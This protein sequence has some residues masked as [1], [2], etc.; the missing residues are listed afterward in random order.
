[1]NRY[2]KQKKAVEE[3]I[4]GRIDQ[5]KAIYAKAD[6]EDRD[7]TTDERLDIEQHLKAIEVLKTEK[8]EAEENIKTLQRVDDI[9][10]ELGPSVP[11]SMSVGSE[12]HDRMFAQI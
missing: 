11:T 6:E 8:A 1:M 7:P 9:G 12:P 5:Y 10:R 4:R 3:A 2:E